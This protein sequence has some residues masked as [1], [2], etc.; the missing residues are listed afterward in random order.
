[1]ERP[2]PSQRAIEN[3]RF[4]YSQQLHKRYMKYINSGGL[5][6]WGVDRETGI[7]YKVLTKFKKGGGGLNY[8][9]GMRLLKFLREKEIK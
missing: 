7:S 5:S 8:E 1:M 3:N 9:N 6:T 2:N 4:T